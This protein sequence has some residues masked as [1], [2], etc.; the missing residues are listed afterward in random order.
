MSDI[1]DYHLSEE[2]FSDDLDN[3][4]DNLSNSDEVPES[5]NAQLINQDLEIHHPTA[6]N[7]SLKRTNEQLLMLFERNDID[8]YFKEFQNICK[9]IEKN[10]NRP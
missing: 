10:I 5:L 6:A 3:D 2:N 8:T 7:S 4:F 9:L 1:E